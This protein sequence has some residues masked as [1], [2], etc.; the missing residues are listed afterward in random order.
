MT[1]KKLLPV[2]L[3]IFLFS[4]LFTF[5]Q[6]PGNLDLT[7]GNSGKLSISK[8][9]VDGGLTNPVILP[10]NKI[11]AVGTGF[12]GTKNLSFIVRFLP[13]GTIDT[14]FGEQGFSYVFCRADTSNH[15]AVYK[16]F[17]QNNGHIIV[18][19]TINWQGT[20]VSFSIFE[21][22]LSSEGVPDLSFGSNGF[23][24]L[25]SQNNSAYDLYDA[26]QLPG[27]TLLLCGD[28]YNSTNYTQPAFL[29][30]TT[31]AGVPI[32]SFG[33]NGKIF[34]TWSP[35]SQQYRAVRLLPGGG[36]LACGDYID[37]SSKR[38][39][40]VGRYHQNGTL[41]NSFGINGYSRISIPDTNCILSTMA[42]QPDGKIVLGGN[43]E[44]KYT[45]FLARMNSNGTLDNAF[46]ANGRVTYSL[47]STS[48][49]LQG[50]S[51]LNDGRIL[52]NA[53]YYQSG[54]PHG[55]C[56]MF[57]QQGSI[58]PSFGN[59][60]ILAETN[61]FSQYDFSAQSLLS[62][63]K[64]LL[65]G[66][67]YDNNLYFRFLL[68]RIYQDGNKDLSFGPNG[69][70]YEQFQTQKG[71][72]FPSV[73]R[74]GNNGDLILSCTQHKF[75][76]LITADVFQVSA[77]GNPPPAPTEFP[78]YIDYQYINGLTVQQD[79]KS[80]VALNTS[81]E[82]LV[83]RL[84]QDGTPD[85]S[86][87]TNGF[88]DVSAN[89]VSGSEELRDIATDSDGSSYVYGRQ[90]PNNGL[91]T[92]FLPT[93]VIDSA[94]GQDG[95]AAIDVG[96]S[97]FTPHTIIALPDHKQLIFNTYTNNPA[98]GSPVYKLDTDGSLD[99]GF[100]VA[101]YATTPP[102][103]PGSEYSVD[104]IADLQGR[105][106]VASIISQTNGKKK[107]KIIR[108][109]PN[110]SQDMGFGTGGNVLLDAGTDYN[111]FYVYYF[112]NHKEASLA[113]QQD[114][115]IVAVTTRFSKDNPDVVLARFN[116][117]GSP[118]LGFGINGIVT[119]DVYGLDDRSAGI[120][121]QPDNSIVVAAGANDGVKYNAVLLRY[122][123]GLVL[124]V[125][126]FEQGVREMLV[127]PNP[128]SDVNNLRF[129]NIVDEMVTV[130]LEDMMGRPVQSLYS[131]VL[132]EGYHNLTLQLRADLP[133]GNYIYHIST[134]KGQAVVRVTRM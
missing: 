53:Y 133:S 21:A 19:G 55:F 119:T 31:S 96:F 12:N 81:N 4:P 2:L 129:Y 86:F 20:N 98:K 59:N 38:I 126:D 82:R 50:I 57:N 128:V 10:D 79:G 105:I 93:G 17:V 54:G 84:N 30:K 45:L 35:N 107:L 42:L 91:V 66:S 9:T 33:T 48:G 113:V 3:A 62:D 15:L 77:E 73:L 68:L 32:A 100:G 58:S 46:G 61:K 131:G 101:G 88:A 109:Q 120:A 75:G 121:I 64:V 80:V 87:G 18:L 92:K 34:T 78:Q 29:M 27:D 49:T 72:L 41:D 85:A 63:G 115:K 76:P 116:P 23:K 37:G 25:A 8:G 7:F 112:Y 14:S 22:Q 108:Y 36:F 89:Y 71:D 67:S 94:W 83:A 122:L 47:N 127:Y 134:A 60:G 11:L 124:G 118:D 99:S 125:H 130:M 1:F 103:G 16:L 40:V 13:D 26:V 65:V 102:T 44:S 56:A 69:D 5:S 132:P 95:K 6:N 106:L 28:L 97:W 117:D 114:G 110:G 104:A 24:I 90:Y 43:T 74:S 51:I 52:I 111:T 70:G 39:G 123:P